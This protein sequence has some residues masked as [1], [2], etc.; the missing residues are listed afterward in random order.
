MC[1]SRNTSYVI[2]IHHTGAFN[3]TYHTPE[4]RLRTAEIYAAP[5]SPPA[6][7]VRPAPQTPPYKWLKTH[8]TL[9]ILQFEGD[10]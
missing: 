1:N 3:L 2:T 6:S 7:L 10:E 4:V 8:R 9:C 5:L